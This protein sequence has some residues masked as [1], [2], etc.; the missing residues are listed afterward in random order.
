MVHV[1]YPWRV[2]YNFR[3]NRFVRVLMAVVCAL[4]V[5]VCAHGSGA[6]F[7]GNGNFVYVA[8]DPLLRLDLSRPNHFDEV[9]TSTLFGG[10]SVDAV[11]RDPRGNIICVTRH[12]I[13]SYDPKTEFFTKIY[14]SPTSQVLED[15]AC[16]PKDSLLLVMVASKETEDFGDA[17][18]RA[19]CFRAGS[20]KPIQ[21]RSRMTGQIDGP[22]FD[23]YGALYFG[24]GGDLWQGSI[25][26][27]DED[28]IESDRA[29]DPK[30]GTPPSLAISEPIASVMG[31]RIAPVARR[32]TAWYASWNMGVF[33]IAVGQDHLFL[34][35][36]AMGHQKKYLLTMLRPDPTIAHPD[37]QL[38][39]ESFDDFIATLSTVQS[40]PVGILG[41][42]MLCASPDG[43]RVFYNTNSLSSNPQE[44]YLIENGLPPRK[45]P[46]K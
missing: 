17:P 39:D 13:V 45:L 44:Y 10:E 9:A 37:H 28:T 38:S 15:A 24:W 6:V 11:T 1:V 34:G 21:V 33:N 43:R 2:V 31:D 29:R 7:S 23:S 25:Y 20:D 16:N 40:I 46:V 41:L 22:V 27:D 35:M 18:F 5:Q 4:V 19:I 42:D 36:S 30:K 8:A 3:M 26:I 14:D 32:R 12:H